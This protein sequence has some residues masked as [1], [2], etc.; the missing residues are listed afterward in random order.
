[1]PVSAQEALRITRVLEQ[2][3]DGRQKSIR[4]WND[5]FGG[6]HNLAWASERFKLAFGGLFADFAD[7]WCEVVCSAPAER[8]T[9][10]GFRFGTG[11]ED[12]VPADREAQKIWQAN[13]LD[14]W[15]R[16][17]HTEAMVKSRAF[18]LVWVDDPEA[19]VP[20][21]H[22]TVEDAT[23]CIVAYEPGSRRRRVAAL[24]RFDGEDG[25]T[26]ATL[27]LP[28]E[29]WKWRRSGSLVAAGSPVQ[30]GL[31]LPPG[32]ATQWEP[33]GD[34]P[35]QQ[36][37]DNPLKRVPMV[38][39]R[40]RPRLVDDPTP[41]HQAVI[42]LQDATNKLIADM[43]V[44]AEEGAF[45]ARWGTGIDLPKDPLTG[46]EIDDPELWRLS[47]SKMLR[48]SNP[49][50]KFGNFEAAD[51]RNFVAGITMLTEHISAISRTP[52]TYFMG[53]VENV[54]A[55]ALTA[56]EAGLASKCRDKTMFLG[57]D[58][59]EVLRL[60]FLVKGDDKRGNNPLA[61][62]I[63]RDVEYRTEAQHID[64]VLKRKALGVPWRQLM[65]DAG[66]TPTQIDRMERMLE[67]DAD[68]A[69]RALA[70]K[71]PE[72]DDFGDGLDDVGAEDREA[73]AVA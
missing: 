45:P 20:E 63:W 41:E 54:A 70:F 57:E 28:D 6:R 4:V 44:A 17:A 38:E 15:A 16:V 53:K 40:N 72:G 48:A 47:V 11:D 69:A 60:A 1:M 59:E 19:D 46:Q 8:L 65:E 5:F 14:A 31:I 73:G 12:L 26:Y 23:Q 67:Q 51:L 21:P 29:I 68:R 22:I 13:S 58:W 27:Y 50:A 25:F 33:R 66:Y 43:M 10:V 42:P 37:I 49:Q 39:L 30:S 62:T 3:L 55:D 2:K 24:K 18:V 32:L 71:T 35:E 7:N 36:R 56:S 9:P 52:P 61:E 34:D 64:A